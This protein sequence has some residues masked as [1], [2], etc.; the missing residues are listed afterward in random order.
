MVVGWTG[1]GSNPYSHAF[2]SKRFQSKHLQPR[3]LADCF[4]FLK[5]KCCQKP[6]TQDIRKLTSNLRSA[7]Y[8]SYL[9]VRET[10]RQTPTHWFGPKDPQQLGWHWAKILTQWVTSNMVPNIH[11]FVGTWTGLQEM[12]SQVKSERECKSQIYMD[13][14]A[15]DSSQVYNT[16]VGA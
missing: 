10:K 6:T 15:L 7:Y 2:K 1:Q 9:K 5:P 4:L 3:H 16:S 13:A 8:S 11:S 14:C 12:M